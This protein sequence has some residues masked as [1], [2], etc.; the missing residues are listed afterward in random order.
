MGFVVVH[1]DGDKRLEISRTSILEP[2]NLRQFLKCERAD[3]FLR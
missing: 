3:G 1:K 2:Q